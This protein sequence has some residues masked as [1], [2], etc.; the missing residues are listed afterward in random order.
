MSAAELIVGFFSGVAATLLA[1]PIWLTV[2]GFLTG[3]FSDLPRVRG[4]W[5]AEYLERDEGNKRDLVALEMMEFSQ[6]GRL[7]WGTAYRV[8]DPEI[9]FT[10]RGEL[11]RQLFTGTFAPRG[12]NTAN[13]RGAFQLRVGDDDKSMSGWC[14]WNDKHTRQIEAT[15]IE[16]KRHVA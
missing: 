5:V 13:A 4:K 3:L 12:V 1:K 7:V 6:A 16:C 2:S 9:K 14:M 8:D 10:Y 11:K 15:V